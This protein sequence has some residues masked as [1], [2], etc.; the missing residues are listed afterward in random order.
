MVTF[1]LAL[2]EEG[3]ELEEGFFLISRGLPANLALKGGKYRAGFGKLNSVHPH[4]Y[5]FA[6]RFR[7]LTA[8]LPGEESLNDVGLQLSELL[9]VG[10]AA[11]T[12]SVD[13][14]RGGSYRVERESSGAANDPIAADP[15][16][17]DLQGEPRPDSLPSS[18]AASVKPMEMPAPKEADRPTRKVVHG[19]CVAKA[20]AKMGASVD[21]EPS[22]RPARPGC[23][24]VRMNCR[25]AAWS[26]APRSSSP[27]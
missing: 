15:E 13:W 23:T 1:T 18:W 2:G 16:N 25:R 10:N 11:V 22:I 7:V 26:S 8:Y 20:V 14:L 19:S 17:G 4:A 12:V 24:Q 5:P 6:G 9:P 27:R 21:T 3:L